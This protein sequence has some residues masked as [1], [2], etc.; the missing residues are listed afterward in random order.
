M[1]LLLHTFYRSIYTRRND[2]NFLSLVEVNLP[3]Y[4]LFIDK[5]LIFSSIS[6]HFVIASF[7]LSI[8][9]LLSLSSSLAL[10]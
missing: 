3:G 2:H 4:L 1:L 9:E 6:L 10:V 7:E 5:L 8:S